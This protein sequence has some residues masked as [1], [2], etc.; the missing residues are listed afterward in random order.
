MNAYFTIFYNFH[1]NIYYK[2]LLNESYVYSETKCS[3][4][5]RIKQNKVLK[6]NE[7][8]YHSLTDSEK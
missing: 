3:A 2:I 1:Q 4:S 8:H 7:K 6:H 5:I